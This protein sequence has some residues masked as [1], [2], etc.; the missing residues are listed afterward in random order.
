MKRV[1]LIIICMLLLF[2][3]QLTTISQTTIS[4]KLE[5][6]SIQKKEVTLF[7]NKPLKIKEKRKYYIICE[8]Y[9]CKKKDSIFAKDQAMI[10]QDSLGVPFYSVADITK[11]NCKI[12][13]RKSNK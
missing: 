2:I 10:F 1:V 4:D 6:I 5:E 8:N 13:I 7:Y 11:A 3:P 12:I 9:T